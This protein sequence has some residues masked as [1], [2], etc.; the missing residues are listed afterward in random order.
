MECAES[1]SGAPSTADHENS[2]ERAPESRCVG[3]FYLLVF[4]T[5]PDVF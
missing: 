4:S 2:A 3:Y 5:Y 1:R